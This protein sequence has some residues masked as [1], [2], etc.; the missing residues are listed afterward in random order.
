MLRSSPSGGD[1]HTA[2][3]RPLRP[4]LRPRVSGALLS[5]NGRED[6]SERS[7]P[8]R[9]NSRCRRFTL[10]LHPA[11]L[12]VLQPYPQL[13]SLHRSCSCPGTMTPSSVP[14]PLFSAWTTHRQHAT[15][16]RLAQATLDHTASEVTVT[17]PFPWPLT[18]R[19]PLS[20][21]S[22]T[23]EGPFFS[24][25]F[26]ILIEIHMP[27]HII[28]HLMCTDRFLVCSLL[29]NHWDDLSLHFHHPRR[30]AVISSRS[31]FSPS[32]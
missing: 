15:C 25:I 20:T 1:R 22:C 26:N 14:T 6:L 11:L 4:V 18:P 3:N 32:P 5:E 23:S 29:C 27:Y 9:G 30:N 21:P 10:S 16:A 7:C 2:C 31:T 19:S 12:S 17:P 24:G 13:L 8:G 28:I